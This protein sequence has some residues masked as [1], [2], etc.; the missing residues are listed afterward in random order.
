[1][2]IDDVMASHAIQNLQFLALLGKPSQVSLA[3]R[4][5]GFLQALSFTHMI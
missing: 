5:P 3:E 2:L 4:K 1:M